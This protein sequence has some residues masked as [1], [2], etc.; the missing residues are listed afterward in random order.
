M[1]DDE[2]LIGAAARQRSRCEDYLSIYPFHRH[3]QT[4]TLDKWM[5]GL[6]LSVSYCY[7]QPL[8]LTGKIASIRDA[9]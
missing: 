2:E 5:D 8:L 4:Y 7:Q 9:F 3:Q 6:I 1:T